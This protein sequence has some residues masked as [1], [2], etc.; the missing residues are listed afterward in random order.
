MIS[1]RSESLSSKKALPSILFAKKLS[2]VV[3]K[4]TH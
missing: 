4:E 3:G 2:I 1:R